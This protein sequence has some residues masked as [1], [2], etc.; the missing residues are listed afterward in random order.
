M[1]R[2]SIISSFILLISNM[3]CAVWATTLPSKTINIDENTKTNTRIGEINFLDGQADSS[4]QF[5]IGTSAI[6]NWSTNGEAFEPVSFLSPFST[7]PIVFS[8][9]QS[10]SDY[11]VEYEVSTY[12]FT[13]ALV[14]RGDDF[15]MRPRMKNVSTSGFDAILESELDQRGTSVVTS[16]N[17]TGEPETV[18]WMAISSSVEGVWYNMP[19]EVTN[20]GVNVTENEYAQS[21][22]APFSDI[23]NLLSTITTYSDQGQTGVGVNKVSTSNAKIYM[24]D[25]DDE[26]HGAENVSL[27]LLQGTGI[28]R[29]VNGIAIGESGVITVEDSTVDTPFTVSLLKQ[30]SNPVVFVQA[31]GIDKTIYDATVRLTAITGTNFSAYLHGVHERVAPTTSGKFS[32]HYQVYEAGSWTVPLEHY[33]YEIVSGNETGAFY[34][35]EVNGNIKVADQTQL[36][37]ETGVNQFNFVVRVTDGLGNQYDTSVTVNVEDINDSLNNDAQIISGLTA[38]DWAGWSVAPAGDVNGDSFDDIIV[39]VPQADDNGIDAGRAYVLFSDSSGTLPDLTT[40]NAGSNGFIIE[41]ALTGDNAGFA[42]SGGVDINGDGLSDVVVGAPYADNNGKNSGSTYVIFGKKNTSTVNLSDFVMD[43]GTLGYAIHGAY[44][45]DYSGGTLVTGDVNGDGL[46]DVVIGEPVSRFL[47]GTGSFSMENVFEEGVADPN[48][49]YVAYGKTS[50]VAINLSSLALDTDTSGFAVSRNS[51]EMNPAWNY[52]AQVLS[53]GDFNSDGLTDFII[54]NGL[55]GDNSGTNK[56]VFGRVGGTSVNYSSIKSDGNGITIHSEDGDYGFDFNNSTLNALPSFTTSNVGDINADGIDDVAL[57]LTDIGCC[58]AISHPRAYILFG[59]YTGTEI[60]LEDIAAGEGG[61]II[62]NDASSIDFSK[63]DVTLG[64]IGGAGDLNGD[65]FDDV[66][67][68]DPYAEDNKG[69]VYA[70]YGKSNT[71]PVYI[72]EAIDTGEGF[73]SEGNGGEQ[74]GQWIASA[75]DVNGD[76]IKDIQF[77]TPSA[78][79]NNMLNNGAVYVLKGNAD[80]ITHVGTSS[81]DTVTGDSTANN[82][83]TGMGNDIVNGNGGAD[84][85]YTGPGNDTI[86]VKDNNFMRIDGGGGTD[87]IKLEGQNLFLNLSVASSR[88][89]SVEVFDIRGTGANVLSLNKSVSSNSRIRILADTDDAVYSAN[90]QWTNTGSTQTIDN[91]TYQV[92][93]I[94]SAEML[95]QTGVTVTINNAPT[96]AAQVFTVSEYTRGGSQIGVVTASSNDV[97]DTV[98]YSIVSGNSNNTFMIDSTTGALAIEYAKSRL[99]YEEQSSYALMIQVEDSYGATS[100]ATITVDVNDVDIISHTF[101]AD[102]SGTE[103]TFGSTPVTD[104]L[105]IAMEDA[106]EVGTTLNQDLGEITINT[107]LVFNMTLGGEVFFSPSFA[108]QG[109]QVASTVPVT[110][111]LAYADEVQ[112]GQETLITTL[113]E[114]DEGAGFTA[115]SPAFDL[116]LTVG[117]KDILFELESSIIL[118]NAG[119]PFHKRTTLDEGSYTKTLQ[120][121][122]LGAAATQCKDA[123]DADACL[124]T[125]NSTDIEPLRMVAS[126]A[127]DK[128]FEQ[129][130][131][132]GQSWERW[133]ALAGAQAMSGGREECF[134]D[135]FQPSGEDMFQRFDYAML[136]TFVSAYAGLEQDFYLELRP[137]ATLTLEDGSTVRFKADEDIAFTPELHHD[138]NNDGVI[139]AVLVV[140]VYSVF[141]NKTYTEFGLTMPFK[142]GEVNYNVQEAICTSNNI[143]LYGD[144]GAVYQTGGFG[145]VLDFEFNIVIPSMEMTEWYYD[146]LS[147]TAQ[148]AIL[149]EDEEVSLPPYLNNINEFLLAEERIEANISFDLCDNEG[150]C[151]A[152]VMSFKNNAPVA[153]NVKTTGEHKSK[154][155]VVGSYDYSDYENDAEIGTTFQWYRASDELG[156]D[157]TPISGEIYNTYTYTALDIDNFVRFCVRPSDE[158]NYG[159][160]ACSDWEQVA[161]SFY[162]DLSMLTGFGQSIK[163]NGV[164][165]SMYQTNNSSFNPGATSFTIEA[166][167]KP[168]SLSDDV[169]S[170]IIAFV[171]ST[172]STG[173]LFIKPS[174]MLQTNITGNKFLSDVSVTL[175]EWQ[176]IAMT[177]EIQSQQ[178]SVYLDGELVISEVDTMP[179]AYGDL[180]WGSNNNRNNKFFDGEF[181]EIRLWSEARSQAV[182]K[183]NRY[184]GVSASNSYLMSY[185][186]FDAGSDNSVIDL[187]GNSEM[188]LMNSP[189][190]K[191]HNQF[192]SFDGYGDHVEIAHDSKFD[193]EGEDFTIQAK[194]Y[195]KPATGNDRTRAIISKKFG[196]GSMAR[197]WMLRMNASDKLEFQYTAKDANNKFNSGVVLSNKQWYHVA[198]SVDRTANL[199]S[200]YI[201]G[202]LVNTQSLGDKTKIAN[203][204]PIRIGGYSGTDGA[205]YGFSGNMD[206]VIIW[207]KLLNENEINECMNAL[208]AGCDTQ[209]MLLYDFEDEAE[210]NKASNKYNGNVV[211]AVLQNEAIGLSFTVDDSGIYTGVLPLANGISVS[212]TSTP[213]NGDLYIDEYTGAF[214]YTSDGDSQ[215]TTDSFSYIIYNADDGYSLSKQ[216][217]IIR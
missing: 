111:D 135:Y 141:G 178:L 97:G 2:L 167:I 90:N 156:T 123:I 82:I 41:G 47:A 88:V 38:N 132:W 78:N 163:L 46:A 190:Y 5:Q 32:L 51:R 137:I 157:S 130:V 105:N 143:Y 144:Q 195:V 49:A 27:M 3:S 30:Y 155:T 84:A 71:D 79:T 69:R 101:T 136:D 172:S 104:L 37:F 154:E 62:H 17:N 70:I 66:I 76:G 4:V 21:L 16:I 23:P 164:D 100:A 60:N 39:G 194:I 129:E 40:V 28:L 180:V 12:S 68:G 50:G 99:D 151:G 189:E 67:I 179:D 174:G 181:D 122:Q 119:V 187:A 73:F 9:I 211:G 48:L 134:E 183:A 150:A 7:T 175:G 74:L 185:F 188:S 125:E 152:P 142:V 204:L 170:N 199:A 54:N 168:E 103:S 10:A 89:R 197:G 110:M 127:D 56:V 202:E 19:F 77:G 118:D 193:F 14:A 173:M 113:F 98:S 13:G 147:D 91:I 58:S 126:L 120:S 176:H 149:G 212:L 186:N 107:G 45:G 148:D 65:G 210:N 55:Y 207:N 192:M 116:N 159:T 133:Y 31:T 57:L 11:K 112:A 36:D 215:V 8:H 85:I 139:D 169:N 22:T 124:V 26:D 117:L 160:F 209:L 171:D 108:L 205:A 87:T 158:N 20:T 165:Q 208:V 191:K 182:I 145:P 43:A 161:T 198:V 52:G 25:I 64:S 72:S 18:G 75:G 81:N 162:K 121:K 59:G 196:T 29:D 214:T 15:I 96:I 94:G 140:D 42:V 177:Y 115:S 80:A 114:M 83:A 200:M 1:T 44:L 6:Q 138:T 216:V 86:I 35:D 217:T 53:T 63:L 61:F 92:Y 33:Q 153:S 146:E 203:T 201:D 184:L 34:V 24:D 131:Y 206:D 93:Q 109:G 95:V 102:L 106:N 213:A 166:W 128:W